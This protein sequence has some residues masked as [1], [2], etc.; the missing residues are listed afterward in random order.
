MRIR[1]NEKYEME[2]W[3]PWVHAHELHDDWDLDI[4][5]DR[6]CFAALRGAVNACAIGKDGKWHWVWTIDIICLL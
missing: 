2:G 1:M 5:M 3:R 6:W 4:E